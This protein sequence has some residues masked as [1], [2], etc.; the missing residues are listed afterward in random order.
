MPREV[1]A[2][3]ANITKYYTSEVKSKTITWQPSHSV[4]TL[5]YVPKK[6]SITCNLEQFIILIHF[7]SSSTFN[8]INMP[9]MFGY[10][11]ERAFSVA[12]TLVEFGLLY[13]T[14]EDW[15]LKEDTVFPG[16][17]I[18]LIDEAPIMESAST[19]NISANRSQCIEA[20]IVK[21]MKASTTLPIDKL[22]ETVKGNI[23]LFTA[24]EA[25]IMES[26][27]KCRETDFI[28]I[29]ENNVCTYIS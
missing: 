1:E 15:K 28:S 12:N 19:D 11:E 5:Y 23:K 29:D 21:V 16:N 22:I 7:N 4:F 3:A 8:A 18:D 24:G 14:G 26:I 6:I 13:K 17:E 27:K 9:V 20:M 25:Q 2:L 10:S